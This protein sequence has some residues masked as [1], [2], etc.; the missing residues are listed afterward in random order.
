[1][2]LGPSW[3]LLRFPPLA[4]ADSGS[5]PLYQLALPLTAWTGGAHED[6]LPGVLMAAGLLLTLLCGA[7]LIA[8]AAIRAAGAL[9]HAQSDAVLT[10]PSPL[11]REGE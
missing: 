8:W 1:M 10:V 2:G 9:P 4:L 11:R 6:A 7:L 5:A 3:R